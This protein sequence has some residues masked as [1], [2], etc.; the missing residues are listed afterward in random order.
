MHTL[1]V[2][3]T[4]G[5]SISYVTAMHADTFNHKDNVT[6]WCDYSNIIVLTCSGHLE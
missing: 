6:L 2:V 4:H 5:Y 3:S 1:D